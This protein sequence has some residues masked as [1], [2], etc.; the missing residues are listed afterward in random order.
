MPHL[1]DN[2]DVTKERLKLK[3]DQ[4]NKAENTANTNMQK[5]QGRQTLCGRLQQLSPLSP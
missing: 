3:N 4:L 5:T 1:H 2:I